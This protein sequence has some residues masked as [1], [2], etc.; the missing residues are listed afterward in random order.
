MKGAGQKA[1]WSVRAPWR[2]RPSCL[3]WPS[4]EAGEGRAQSERVGRQ[5]HNAFI[6]HISRHTEH[7]V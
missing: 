1:F 7:A 6:S 3:Q 5:H 4:V 2:L